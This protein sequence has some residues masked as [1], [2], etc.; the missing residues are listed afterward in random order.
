MTRDELLAR[1][2]AI[3][4][5]PESDH[6]EADQLLLKFIDDHEITLAFGAIRKWYA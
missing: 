4:G 6:I 5:E 2:E 3:G 1:L